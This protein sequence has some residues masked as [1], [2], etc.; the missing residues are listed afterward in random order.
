[1]FEFDVATPESVGI[2]S[3]AIMGFAKEMEEH[4]FAM[5]SLLIVKD[6]KLVC[7][8][9]WNPVKKDDL[10]RMYSITKTFTSLAIGVLATEGKIKLSDHIIDY[11][12]DKLPSIVHPYL[13][14]V[15]IRDMLTMETCHRMTTYK[16][17]DDPDWTRTFFTLKPDHM[18][19]SLFMYDTSS[20]HV[21]G[22][23]VERVSGMKLLDFLRKSFLDEIE[24]SKDAY[25]LTDPVGVPISGSGL[26]CRSMDLM[27]VIYYVSEGK[28]KYSA[29]FK[30]ACSK[31]V[32]TGYSGLTDNDAEQG[33]GYFV[34]MT[35]RGG[36]SFMGMGGQHAIYIPEKNMHIVTTAFCKEAEA[37]ERMML[38][39]IW[40]MVDKVKDS[41]VPEDLST[42]EWKEKQKSLAIP[43]ATGCL[44]PS[45]PLSGEYLF[46]ENSLGIE[47]VSFEKNVVSMTMSGKEY[48]LR[49][50]LG[51]NVVSPFAFCEKWDAAISGSY[52]S[53]GALELLIQLLGEENGSMAIQFAPSYEKWITV[54]IRHWIEPKIPCPVGLASGKRP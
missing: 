18:P 13:K 44:D 5:H 47:R 16:Q 45:A 35:R 9:Y 39:S 19:G 50:G 22:A 3:S 1:M 54:R 12:P 8:A 31:Q 4:R 25:I 53:Q 37:Y 21:L 43:V 32:D 51:E 7:D 33:Y 2:P 30:E 6:G 27:K 10:H 41:P 48:F 40:R 49:Y 17:I 29:Y 14:A 38:D 36:Y 52:N 34:W 42:L 24:F 15:T 20:S 46:G 28:S 23:L 11:F 26:C